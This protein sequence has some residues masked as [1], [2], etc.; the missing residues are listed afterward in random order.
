MFVIKSRFLL[1]HVLGG[2]VLRQTIT[3]NDIHHFLIWA[4]YVH[5]KD[6][7]LE[8]SSQ[9]SAARLTSIIHP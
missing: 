9:R 7:L 2:A 3:S 1:E 8:I 5:T 4:S 6:F